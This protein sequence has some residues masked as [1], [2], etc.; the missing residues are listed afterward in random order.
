MSRSGY[1]FYIELYLRHV[2]RHGYPVDEE[3][4]A[5]NQEFYGVST[6]EREARRNASAAISRI[7]YYVKVGTLYSIL[8]IIFYRMVVC[9]PGLWKTPSC[10]DFGPM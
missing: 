1:H 2:H 10:I 6:P 7:H 9:L 8:N 3:R 4:P 5:F